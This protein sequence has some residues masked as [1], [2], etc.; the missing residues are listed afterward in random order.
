MY[1]RD[2]AIYADDAIVD[3]FPSGFVSWFHRESCCVTELYCSLL[4]K[5]VAT[6]DAAKAHLDFV[7]S[8]GNEPSVRQLLNVADVRWPFAFSD[9]AALVDNDAKKRMLFDALH[10]A[11]LWLAALRDWPTS[12]LEHCR[13]E[14]LSRN[15]TH[16]GWSKQT[17]PDPSGKLR[18]K[19]GFSFELRSV[20]FYVGVFDRRGR[21]LG[22][23]P[24]GAVVPEMGVTRPILKGRGEW[25][26][27]NKFRVQLGE[28]SF[29]LPRAWEV[30]LAALVV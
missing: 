16:T 5:H 6:S 13:A 8:A 30:D 14:A 7:D 19:I 3:R 9:Y 21:E 15:L 2:L 28:G 27:A 25:D 24:L 11:L 20:E 26:A 18:A 4:G 23:K 10:A 1:L 17:W 29:Y 22:R 12:G